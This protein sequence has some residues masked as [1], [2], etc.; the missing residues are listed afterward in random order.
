[1]LFWW[2]NQNITSFPKAHI[3]FLQFKYLLL[4]TTV[5]AAFLSRDLASFIR[6]CGE[7]GRR[8]GLNVKDLSFWFAADAGKTAASLLKYYKKYKNTYTRGLLRCSCQL[9]IVGGAV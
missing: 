7:A 3:I 4:F 5:A 6:C 2:L 1:M 8:D 9:I